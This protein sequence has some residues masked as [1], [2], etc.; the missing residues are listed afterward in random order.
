M[1]TNLARMYVEPIPK[2]HLYPQMIKR[3]PTTVIHKYPQSHQ[4]IKTD[5]VE[6]VHKSQSG[7]SQQL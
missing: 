5:H 1:S 7:P 6:N 4:P 3:H 2:N